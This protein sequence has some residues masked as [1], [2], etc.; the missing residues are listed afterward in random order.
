MEIMITKLNQLCVRD[1]ISRLVLKKKCHH[2]KSRLV[3]CEI[4]E[5]EVQLNTYVKVKKHRNISKYAQ[6]ILDTARNYDNIEEILK[7]LHIAKK[8]KC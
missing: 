7:I 6:H 8:T 2:Q 3:L 4:S 5:S 1:L